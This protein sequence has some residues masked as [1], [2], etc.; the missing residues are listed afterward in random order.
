MN[1]FL[2]WLRRR[3]ARS[4]AVSLEDEVARNDAR[5]AADELK[6]QQI[7]ERIEFQTRRYW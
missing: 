4:T 3:F 5:K 2:S 6:T 7:A 1:A